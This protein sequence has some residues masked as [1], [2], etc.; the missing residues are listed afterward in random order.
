MSKSRILL[1][2]AALFVTLICWSLSS[3]INSHQDEK[4]HLASIW[5]ADG[6]E[7][8]CENRGFSENGVET[9]LI[10]ANLCTPANTEESKY[11]RLLIQRDLGDCKYEATENEPLE[12][13]S[14]SPNFFY[15]TDTQIAAWIQ[16]GHTPGIYYKALN[17]F[18]S[19]NKEQSVIQFRIVNSLLFVVLVTAFLLV[20]EQ[21]IRSSA[22]FGLFATLIPHGLFLVS[23]VTNSSW[24][25]AGCSLSWAFLYALLNQPFRFN[26]KTG[27]TT[28]GWIASSGIVI[29]S[30]YDATIL[31]FF[32]NLTVLNLHFCTSAKHR[33]TLLF[34]TFI[35][36]LI[37]AR[38]VWLS[39]PKIRSLAQA[40]NTPS[41]NL[42]DLLINFGTAIKLV[43]ATSLRILGLQ[44]PGW[45]PLSA[46]LI[47]FWFNLLFF[48]A[49]ISLL[50][51]AVKKIKSIFFFLNLIVLLGILL[52]QI[53]IR[54]DWTTPFYLIRTS[55]S[56]D[57]FS[58]RYFIPYFPFLFGILAVIS[59]NFTT[60]LSDL[61]FRNSL[62]T[63]LAF[64][65]AITLYDISRTFRE[66]PNWYWQ[67]FPIGID[68][69]FLVGI[70]SFIIFLYLLLIAPMT[71]A[72]RKI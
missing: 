57:L 65:Q 14:V 25:Y 63:V 32:T 40:P 52:I 69:V 5:C 55:W 30:R 48:A 50:L 49:T 68:A 45:S 28:L 38:L 18:D 29:S 4:F 19:R 61:N 56:G 66:N 67:N 46:S 70:T 15:E 54:P 39:F 20:S 2:G 53:S 42:R 31:L 11:K 27:L 22:L 26:C 6:F 43:F 23:G 37:T 7:E 34:I 72:K 36:L 24:S 44:S 3:P 12:T 51:S 62:F 33:K 64:T 41:L 9:V 59:K 21:I 10:K 17:F 13:M 16:P 47:V 1:A 71:D 35:A 58:P 8:D 60:V